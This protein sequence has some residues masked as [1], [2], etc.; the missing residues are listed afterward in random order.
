MNGGEEEHITKFWKDLYVGDFVKITDREV[1]PNIFKL[2]KEI[3]INFIDV[4][5]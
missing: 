4:S 3:K 5:S 2:P 1:K